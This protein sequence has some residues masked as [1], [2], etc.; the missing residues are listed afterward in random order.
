MAAVATICW[1]CGHELSSSEPVRAH[2][3]VEETDQIPLVEW[4]EP[5]PSAPVAAPAVQARD[6]VP[7]RQPRN[8]SMALV[9]GAGV[10]ACVTAMVVLQSLQP[11]ASPQPVEASRPSQ[12]AR[13][14]AA[15]PIVESGPTPMWVGSRQAS[16]AND[17]SKTISFELEATNDVTVWMAKVRP[18]LIVR[19]L[20]KTTEVFV[21]TQSAASIEGQ[22]GNHTVR[23]NIDDDQELVQ[24]WTD[25]VSGHE[26]FSPNGVALARRLA[27]AQRLR[28]SFTPY[29]ANPVTAEFALQDVEKLAGLVGNTCG[30]KLDESGQTRTAR[31]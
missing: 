2:A 1:T 8:W 27:T 11:A 19:C 12:P 15:A 16:W 25:S 7:A 14:A 13:A 22:S 26:L 17:G 5:D 24:Q 29:N 30:W 9:G 10:L 18:L 23:L 28:F 6:A 3:E 4:K 20:Y 21:A 31:R